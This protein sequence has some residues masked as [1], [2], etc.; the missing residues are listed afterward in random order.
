MTRSASATCCT[1]VS[2]THLDVY[3]RQQGPCEGEDQH[4]ADH[5]LEALGDAGG[6]VLKGHHAAHAVEHK[7]EQQG[8][9]CL[10]YTSRCV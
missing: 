10:L 7:G 8:D 4:G 6:N 5:G 3:K 2:Y 1:P 9:A